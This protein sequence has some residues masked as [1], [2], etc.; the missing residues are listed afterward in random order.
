MPYHAYLFEARSLQDYLF[1]GGK[2]AD[3][4]ASSDLLDDLTESLLT[5]VLKSLNL[6]DNPG[7]SF[8]RRAGGAF[9]VIAQGDEGR[10][11]LERLQLLWTLAVPQ[12][13]PRLEFIQILVVDQDSGYLAVQNGI[14]Q[15]AQLRN[16]Q[17]AALPAAGPFTRR[18]PRTG[19]AALRLW[20][21][22]KPV[23]WVDEPLFSRR[24]YFLEYSQERLAAK[25]VTDTE[26]KVTWPRNLNRNEGDG[27]TFPFLNEEA[28]V[29][30]I[31]A[32]GNGLGQLLQVLG[33]ISR[34][35]TANYARLFWQFSDGLTRATQEAVTRATSDVLLPA[36]SF[37]GDHAVMPARP[38]VLG[39]D[40]LTIIVR[41]DLAIRFAERFAIEFER[42][43]EVFLKKLKADFPKIK[44]QDMPRKLTACSGI[45]FVKCGQPFQMAY[46]LAESL[47]QA[48][49]SRSRAV[50]SAQK[51]TFSPSSMAFHRLTG[52]L[53]DDIG[54]VI[55]T[56]LTVRIGGETGHLSFVTYSIGEALPGLPSLS[57]LR[58]LCRNVPDPRISESGT[59]TFSKLRGLATLLHIDP[60]GAQVYWQRML[61]HSEKAAAR[62]GKSVRSQPIGR[63]IDLIQAL[64][65]RAEM[66]MVFLR[67][68]AGGSIK[69]GD[70]AWHSPLNDVLVLIGMEGA[71]Q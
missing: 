41:A 69:D 1:S 9:Y 67:K 22:S 11:Q 33:R 13:L 15:L 16:L 34:Q 53:A 20:E 37:K 55:D 47:C 42:T 64:D 2:L 45:A 57:A 60:S 66:N 8:V 38:L 6:S 27:A 31:H 18:A 46:H 68:S 35:D 23:E 50:A 10:Q 61:N 4:V 5:S 48:A 26:R 49:K 70:A 3:M 39:G 24:S 59:L 29:A 63:F 54:E 62:T 21:C 14:Q 17:G 12:W 32:D 56:E 52:S 40:D 44:D 7:L 43:T 36:A 28:D 65:T 51:L 30:I 71:G 25:F 19:R 58:E